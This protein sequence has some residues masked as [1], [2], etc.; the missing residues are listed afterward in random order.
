MSLDE[1][2]ENKIEEE[3]D[4]PFREMSKEVYKIMI[5]ERK[6]YENNKVQYGIN[7]IYRKYG[8]KKIGI[9]LNFVKKDISLIELEKLINEMND[10][11]YKNEK[12]ENSYKLNLK[13]DM[14]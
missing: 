2:N 13:F 10:F 11:S 9:I 4:F 3:N 14:I 1:R 8:L 6:E 12:N 5:D 7:R